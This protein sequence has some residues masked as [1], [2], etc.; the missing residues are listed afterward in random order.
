M[1]SYNSKFKNSIGTKNCKC[2]TSRIACNQV[3]CQARKTQ[4][5]SAI[6]Q[7]TKFRGAING[8]FLH[9]Q[10]CLESNSRI[11]HRHFRTT[12]KTRRNNKWD[13]AMQISAWWTKQ[14]S[15]WP[16]LK[17][18]ATWVHLNFWRLKSSN[19]QN[20]LAKAV[21][22]LES[23]AMIIILRNLTSLYFLI[24][25]SAKTPVLRRIHQ[26]IGVM[27]SKSIPVRKLHLWAVAQVSRLITSRV[28]RVVRVFCL[29]VFL[30]K[31]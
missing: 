1:R 8:T 5:K 21:R 13:H 15:R 30:K 6:K 4:G 9:F 23:K 25:R 14:L 29:T 22:N 17:V 7:L 18:Q 16:Y 20:W 11:I 10:P 3:R 24:V 31:R 2:Y 26:V 28:V 27:A 12:S 19:R